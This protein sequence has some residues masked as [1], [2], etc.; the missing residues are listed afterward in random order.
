MRALVLTLFLGAALAAGFQITGEVAYQARAPLGAFG[1]VNPTL[2]GEVAYDPDTGAL[3]GRVCL[4]LAA[5]DSKE[6][7]RDR[8]TREMFQVDRYPQ[9]CLEPRSLDQAKGL[10]LGTLE[11]HGVRK[12]VAWPVRYTLEGGRLRFQAE[13]DLLLGDYGLKAP[14]F[15][16]M[17]VQERVRVRVQG[18]GVAR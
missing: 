3:Q 11:L 13:F 7:L 1:G 10:L 5:W 12:E 8:H 6:P 9:A 4:D 18:E 17:R 16:G 14:S 2:K 15:M